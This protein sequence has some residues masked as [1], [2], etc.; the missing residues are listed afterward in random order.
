MNSVL[1]HL[2]SYTGLV[3]ALAAMARRVQV[4]LSTPLHL[5][6]ELYPVAHE[7]GKR[8][9]YGGSYLEEVD[10]WTKPR[11]TNIFNEIKAMALEILFLRGVWEHNR[12]LWYRSFP[13]HFGLYLVLA[14][15]ALLVIGAFLQMFGF[16]PAGDGAL[17]TLL[18]VKTTFCGVFGFLLTMIGSAGLFFRRYLDEDLRNY[19]SSADFFNLALIFVTMLT[20]FCSYIFEDHGFFQARAYVHSLLTFDFAELGG[21]LFGVQVL[22][23][24]VLMA[25]I[26]LTHMAHFFTKYFFYHDIRWNDTPNVRGETYDQQISEV[27]GYKLN[28]NAP[29]IKAE[30]K[31]TWAQVA[32]EETK[33][34]D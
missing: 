28:W 31:K 20:A 19:S 22:L 18:R 11:H 12:S 24:A 2:L 5:R 7:G 13:F 25:Y 8:A 30:G 15:L 14:W 4:Y 34:N 26:P 16:D 10:W 32:T 33:D 29:H 3:V 17:A 27:L 1:L 6:W 9:G 21:V 23:G